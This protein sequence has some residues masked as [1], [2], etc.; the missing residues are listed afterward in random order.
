MF[1]KFTVYFFAT[2][3][4]VPS[5]I[6]GSKV[7]Y[8]Y[9]KDKSNEEMIREISLII[10]GNNYFNKLFKITLNQLRNTQGN[11]FISFEPFIIGALSQKIKNEAQ[12]KRNILSS[13]LNQELIASELKELYDY[14]NS[15]F[16]KTTHSKVTSDEMLTEITRFII[17]LSNI[18]DKRLDFP[19]SARVSLSKDFRDYFTIID[20]ENKIDLQCQASLKKYKLG[21]FNRNKK[22]KARLLDCENYYLY[23]FYSIYQRHF[24][25]EEIRKINEISKKVF[26]KKFQSMIEYQ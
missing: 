21:I 6:F 23:M 17:E 11:D 4:V 15:D 13:R 19:Q 20:L 18:I 22:R 8:L 10:Y 9:K 16:Y 24:D 5:Y 25:D 14:L 1:F 26:M 2:F 7:N 3:F 12:S